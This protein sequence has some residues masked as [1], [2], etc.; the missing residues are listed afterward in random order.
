LLRYAPRFH[1][2]IPKKDIQKKIPKKNSQ[3]KFP[4]K[5]QQKIRFI[6][7]NFFV[8]LKIFHSQFGVC[9][10]K[11]WGSRPAGLGVKGIRT[12]SSKKLK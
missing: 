3:K 1:K 4:K 12:N 8:K 7:C 6:F 9:F 10:K 5:F 11:N 2:K